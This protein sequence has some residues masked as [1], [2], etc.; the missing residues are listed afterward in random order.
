MTEQTIASR[1]LS[2]AK[3]IAAKLTEEIER[4]EQMPTGRVSAETAESIKYRLEQALWHA[5]QV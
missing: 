3:E 1:A 4:L 2:K 5:E